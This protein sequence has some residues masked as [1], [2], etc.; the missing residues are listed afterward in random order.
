MHNVH[1]IWL[2]ALGQIVQLANHGSVLELALIAQGSIKVM[3]KKSLSTHSNSLWSDPV[4]E[5]YILEYSLSK[6]WL[7]ELI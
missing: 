7:R 1:Y 6:R 3:M 5:T 2:S 4:T